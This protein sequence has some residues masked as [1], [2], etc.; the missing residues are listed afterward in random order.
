M[1]ISKKD[2]DKLKKFL[3]TSGD[4]KRKQATLRAEFLVESLSDNS[5]YSQLWYT[6]SDLKS[7]DFIKSFSEYAEPILEKKLIF[8]PKFVSW[9]CPHCESDF[10]RKNCVSNGKYCALQHDD[11]L[12]LD[13]REI[14]EEN[15]RQHC[16]FW[17]EE[18]AYGTH[19]FSKKTRKSPKSLFFE[20]VKRAVQVCRN[21]ITKE[22]S[23]EIAEGLDIDFELVD[24][25][26]KATFEDPNDIERS[27]NNLLDSFAQDWM[28]LGSHF[29][30]AIVIN[31][32]T[33]RGR[34]TPFNAFEAIC[35]S[36][37]DEPR[38]CRKWQQFEG[39]PLPVGQS[40]GINQKTLFLIVVG[41]VLTNS[42]IILVYRKYLQREME[43]D[44]KIQVSSAV[45]QY[46]AL[47]QIPELNEAS[48]SQSQ[49]PKAGD[50][51]SSA[52][53]SHQI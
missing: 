10:K 42:L 23:M 52:E 39:I 30:P 5:V 28:I 22:C 2:G 27:N 3:L 33:F 38:E 37:R 46:I 43:K 47:S 9:S 24:D 26:V 32:K 8:E 7:L 11:N 15:L 18:E 14:I 6:S 13:G 25:C 34:L 45:S 44:M 40:T 41:L 49:Q 51:T 1:L 50:P 35:A 36:Y 20:Y 19:D 12:D 31:D 16:L 48:Q 17:M 53:I 4:T 21:R 29:Y